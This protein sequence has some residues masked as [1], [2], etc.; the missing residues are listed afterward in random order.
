VLTRSQ[1][2]GYEKNATR[3]ARGPKNGDAR[4]IARGDRHSFSFVDPI[5]GQ[6][7]CVRAKTAFRGFDATTAA[8]R[9]CVMLLGA[10]FFAIAWPAAALD[11]HRALTQYMLDA[12]TPRL[13]M[14]FGAIYAVTQTPDGYL[15]IATAA[16]G[17]YRFDGAR[18]VH[19]D[20]LGQVF[21]QGGNIVYDVA[22]D[23]RGVIWVATPH[24]VARRLHGKWEIVVTRLY[25]LDIA[26]TND[27][28]MLAASPTSGLIRWRD[29]RATTMRVPGVNVRV[30][31]GNDGDIWVAGPNGLSRVI[32]REITT[33]SDKDGLGD[34]NVGALHLGRSGDLWVATRGGLNRIRKGHVIELITHRDGLPS[35]DVT[36]VFEDRR[37]AVW[38]GT[39]T[40]GVARMSRG[41][42]ESFGVEQGLP[43][44][45]VAG[46]YE[47]LEG[48]LWIATKGGLSR[49]KEG[50]FTPFGT[51]EGLGNDRAVS[52]VEGRDGS[53]WIW[54]DG[55]GLSRLKDGRVRV[56]TKHDGLAS[57]F[58]GPLFEDRR[59]AIWI[60][61]DRGASRFKDGRITTYTK[62]LLGKTYVPFFAEEADGLLTYVFGTGL[63]LLQ[64]GRATPYRPRVY[65]PGDGSSLDQFP[66]PFMAIRTRDGTLWFG[67]R[68]GAWTLRGGELRRVWSPPEGLPIVSWIHEDKGGAVWLATW[69]GLYRLKKGAVGKI[70]TRN[71]LPHNQISHLLEDGL[72]GL[73]LSSPRGVFRI[74]K[75]EAEEVA[76]GRRIHITIEVFGIADGM[77]SPQSLGEAQ[78]AGCATRDGHLWFATSNG[79][80][81]V[82]PAEAKRNTL[83]PSVVIEDV[84]ADGRSRGVEDG[85]RLEAG[86]RYVELQY[87]A[88]SLLAPEK[89]RF[90]YRLDGF[91]G[92]WIDAGERRTAHYTRL[93]PGKYRF[94]VIAAN[95]DG[96]WN[97]VGAA[98][99]FRQLP[100]FH[101]TIW[102]YLILALTFIGVVFVV[103]RLRVRHHLRLERLL[104]ARIEEA[105]ADIKT[106][107][108]LLPI[109]AWCKKVRDDGGYWSRIEEY[110][111]EHTHAEFSHGICPECR[112]KRFGR[113][114]EEPPRG[115]R[116]SESN[117]P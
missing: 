70:T 17:L 1:N 87:T 19:D 79:V 43:D 60:G 117:G 99:S 4:S 62:G 16:E 59:G 67:T 78:P 30:S 13:G 26:L 36:A 72:G 80:I 105:V 33:L 66:M 52:I 73:W 21:G 56:Y 18:F 8:R 90:K 29:G 104:H 25:V 42:V 113:R 98:L 15:W 58:G 23:V 92:H 116:S 97:D 68:A 39:G 20:D 88:L 22:S 100:F 107:R 46:F 74:D 53:V 106:L 38:I 108:G 110:V 11:P 101:Q 10:F 63:V 115:S 44:C 34:V 91:D 93:S 50:R 61:H 48:S 2:A 69:E 94:R 49:F 103:Y 40:N 3:I 71:G 12:W 96:I 14:P 37:G 31:P 41:R 82:D 55:G 95:N 54:S 27:G 7:G 85:I 6:I 28:E 102:F 5:F 47:D 45:S 89:V 9:A 111:S 81:T 114:M 76:A 24:G 51:P 57:N 64:G 112:A 77:R 84:V 83:V 32:G 109:C 65:A 86:T 75:R 35:D